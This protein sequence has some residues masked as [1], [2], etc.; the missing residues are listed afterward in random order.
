M[1]EV[2]EM[3]KHNWSGQELEELKKCKTRQ[4]M[5]EFC[6][7]YKIPIKAAEVR[8][9]HLTGGY[10]PINIRNKLTEEHKK[11]IKKWYTKK[12]AREIAEELGVKPET[13]KTF[14]HR[15]GLKKKFNHS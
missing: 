10:F 13:V 4:E 3:E 14:A 12:K 7:K 11:Y 2:I 15:N 6:E 5:R 1:C 9:Y 8:Y